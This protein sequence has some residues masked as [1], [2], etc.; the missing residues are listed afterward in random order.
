MKKLKL[1]LKLALGFGAMIA[2]AL[3]LGT[4]GYYSSNRNAESIHQI[5]AVNLPA[6]RALLSMTEAANGIKACVRT[7]IQTELEPAVRQRQYET[8]AQ[9]QAHWEA[10]NK[11]MDLLPKTAEE[12]ALWK[13]C[14]AANGGWKRDNDEFFRIA[15]AIDKTTEVY[16]RSER[17]KTNSYLAAAQFALLAIKE[18]GLQFKKQVQEWKDILLRGN[19]AEDYD[20]YL[21]AF[22]QEE[23]LVQAALGRL[24][25]LVQDLGMET[26]AVAKVATLH[27]E[28]GAKYREALKVFD[29][30]NAEAGKA[31]DKAVRGADRPLTEAL[32]GC[33]GSIELA[34]KRATELQAALNQQ[35]MVTCRASQTKAEEAADRLAGCLEQNVA[36]TVKGADRLG[37][38][39]KSMMMVAMGLGIVGG[40]GLAYAITRSI[41]GPIRRVADG[42]AVGAEQ[43]ASAAGQVSS[44]S[45]SLAEGASEQAASLEETSS[46]L[47]EMSSMTKRNAE[48][49]QKANDLAKQARAAA[50][51]GA[52]DMQTMSTAMQAIKQSSDDIAKIIKT[53]DEIAF[54]TNILALNAAVEAA[55]AGE[56]GMGFAVV[57]D[58]VRNLAQRSAQAAK[59]TAA[60]IEGAIAKTAQGVQISAKV[61]EGLQEIVGKVRQVDELVAEV[62]AAS[63]EQSQGIDQVNT[64]VSQM[65][66][67]TQSNAASAEESA[68]AAEELTAQAET[69]REAVEELQA[70]VNGTS[71]RSP[72][73]PL[74]SRP[75]TGRPD[76]R[77]GPRR[78][79]AAAP[80][81]SA[82]DHGH[83]PMT[84]S[85][86]APLAMTG[87]RD[88][89]QPLAEGDFKDF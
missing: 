9:R 37:T 85:Q 32:D 7:L 28:L 31:V 27:N 86:M 66:K 41:T 8:A 56:A 50:D 10:A 2:I 71:R 38:F 78:Q 16:A 61:A 53:I 57:A 26:T 6:T 74:Q 36:T 35:G 22:G 58:E 52:T 30:A 15:R 59:E 76:V 21:A 64:A 5:G 44:A 4:A 83:Q 60:K 43:T 69:L 40:L 81:Q 73:S 67:V 54:Q 63:R 1:N 24:Q 72:A 55:R 87:S 45:Q 19:N 82:S 62:A 39:F 17:A 42:L 14:A 18:T 70:L 34:V 12:A 11:T 23:K 84:V 46:S 20:K 79:A 75:V 77:R 88:R 65:D 25:T 49:A 89:S 29:R 80:T 48:S 13:E 3:F 47:E 33:I 68:S 51:T